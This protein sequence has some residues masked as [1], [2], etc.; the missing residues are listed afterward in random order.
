M[1]LSHQHHEEKIMQP[2]KITI[3]STYDPIP[4]LGIYARWYEA[5]KLTPQQRQDPERLILRDKAVQTALVN[6]DMRFRTYAEDSWTTMVLK[7]IEDNY[8]GSGKPDWDLWVQ[9]EEDV[10]AEVH[11]QMDILHTKRG[12][13]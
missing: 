5:E 10:I 9:R 2:I 12:S 8:F 7:Y 11:L 4:R 3:P 1:K 13:K 6:L